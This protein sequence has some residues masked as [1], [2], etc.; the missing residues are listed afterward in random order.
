VVV[1]L[2]GGLSYHYA[3]WLR[4]RLRLRLHLRLL[5]HVTER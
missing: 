3:L 1:L 4:L 2:P 5:W